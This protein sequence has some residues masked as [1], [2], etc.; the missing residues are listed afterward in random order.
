MNV[1]DTFL[2]LN[3]DTPSH[4]WV[5]IA[6]PTAEDEVAIVNLTTK[7]LAS[8]DTCVV[9][10]G[11]HPFVQHATII[12]YRRGKMIAKRTLDGA[13]E[14]G[15]LLT[16]A[17]VARALLRRIQ[18]GALASRFTQQAIQAAVRPILESDR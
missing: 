17:P 1:G 6:G 18:E 7:T 13:Q 9:T 3:P 11:E 15:Y 5:V 8:D 4:L 16:Q 14:H 2:N 10:K 12:D